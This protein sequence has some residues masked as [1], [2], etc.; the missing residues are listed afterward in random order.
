M[1]RVF[2][3]IQAR[4]DRARGPV[5]VHTLLLAAIAYLGEVNR[6]L[7]TVSQPAESSSEALIEEWKVF[8]EFAA[9]YM[10]G[11]R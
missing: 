10:K 8:E 2:R 9:Q 1:G 3:Q 11:R 6:F 7:M 4:V 5:G